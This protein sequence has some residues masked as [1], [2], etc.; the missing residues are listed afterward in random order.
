MIL[1]KYSNISRKVSRHRRVTIFNAPSPHISQSRAPIEHSVSQRDTTFTS[2]RLK[3]SLADHLLMKMSA[4]RVRGTFR[5]MHRSICRGSNN[6]LKTAILSKARKPIRFSDSIDLPQVKWRKHNYFPNGKVEM[7][8]AEYQKSLDTNMMRDIL[9][10]CIPIID[11]MIHTHKI[12]SVD[13]EDL[14]SE[15]IIILQKSVGWFNPAKAGKTTSAFSYF[16]WALKRGFVGVTGKKRRWYA[17]HVVTDEAPILHDIN[18]SGKRSAEEEN[19]DFV[20]DR[21]DNVNTM[22]MVMRYEIH[23]SEMGDS[24]LKI[25]DVMDRLYGDGE[26]RPSKV[27]AQVMS[28]IPPE[29]GVKRSQVVEM[30]EIGKM[31]YKDILAGKD[32]TKGRNKSLIWGEN[33]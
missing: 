16:S 4:P 29:H 25:M 12:Y 1:T 21:Q 32:M 7:M 23:R 26:L 3:I 17:T 11:G 10:H 31:V 30:C 5:Y 24:Y 33:D 15:G 2:Q 22:L 19:P 9:E 18:V 28:L 20:S 8:I 6:D 13:I 14:R 27:I